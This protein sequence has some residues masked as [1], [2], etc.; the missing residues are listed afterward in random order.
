MGTQERKEREKERRRTEILNAAEE[1][2][3]KKS[4]A[5]ATMDEIAEKAELGKSTIYLYYGSKE[6]IF[7]GLLCRAHDALSELFRKANATGEP[8]IKIFQNMIDVYCQF[9]REHIRYFEMETFLEDTQVHQR[10]SPEMLAE[11][12]ISVQGIWKAVTDV[13]EKG[14]QDGT[15]RKDINPIEVGVIMEINLRGIIRLINQLSLRVMVPPGF[16][17]IDPEEFLKR[18]SSMLT[19]MVLSDEAR[20]NY[21]MNFD[22]NE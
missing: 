2:F 15:F 3:F 6:D 20:K 10:V 22:N 16:Q 8:T 17:K 4:L 21:R 5:Q 13:I 19:Y 1:I 14:I 18:T 12:Q 9:C 7:L 11:C